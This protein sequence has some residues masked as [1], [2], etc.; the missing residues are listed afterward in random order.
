[1]T[2]P[3]IS[4]QSMY[5][6]DAAPATHPDTNT[7]GVQQPMGQTPQQVADRIADDWNAVYANLGSFADEHVAL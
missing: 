7:Q 3:L 6:S 2:I 4:T 1:M 5:V